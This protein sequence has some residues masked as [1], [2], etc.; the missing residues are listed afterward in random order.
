MT[1]V[2]VKSFDQMVHGPNGNPGFTDYLHEDDLRLSQVDC[3]DPEETQC[4]SSWMTNVRLDDI[5]FTPSK[6]IRLAFHDCMPYIDGSGSCDGCINFDDNVLEN[7]VLQ[8]SVAILEK[9]YMEPDYP[10]NAPVLAQAPKDLGISRADLWSFAGVLALDEASRRS[11]SYCDAFNYNLTCGDFAPCFQTFPESF[12][13]LFKTG[14]SD[15]ISVSKHAKKQYLAPLSEDSPNAVANGPM[16]AEYFLRTFDLS[17]REA[18]ALMGA[19]TIGKYSTFHTH[20]DYAWV[21]ARKGMRHRTL[22]NEYYKS[23][24]AEAGHVKDG[25]CVGKLDGSK[26]TKEWHVFANLFEYAWPQ[27]FQVKLKEYPTSDTIFNVRNWCQEREFF[28]SKY[29]GCGLEKEA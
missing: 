20:I 26:A 5:S 4:K 12:E 15:C 16:V 1:K 28:S 17:P 23:L 27:D 24:T 7:D 11:R 21:R 25:Y 13:E 22:N 3:V 2:I 14:R 8:H 29:I 10:A 6:A 19:H 18:L 9:L